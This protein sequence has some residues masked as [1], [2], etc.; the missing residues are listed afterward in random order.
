MAGYVNGHKVLNLQKNVLV[1]TN[2]NNNFVFTACYNFNLP[3]KTENSVNT[4]NN[5]PVPVYKI[6]FNK[7]LAVE[8]VYNNIIKTGYSH[9]IKFSLKY[10]VNHTKSDL[11]FPF[12]WFW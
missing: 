6:L 1:E 12:H 4:I 7:Y 11:L 8:N 5:Y 10:L 2:N 3:I 9:Y